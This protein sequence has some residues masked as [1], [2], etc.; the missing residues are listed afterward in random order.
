MRDRLGVE[1]T[2][3]RE[4]RLQHM[5]DRLAAETTE[6]RETSSQRM[7]TNQR[8]RLAVET[9]EERELR[10]ECYSTRYMEQQSVQPQLP[11]F[12]QCFIQAKMRKFHANM[13]TLDVM[14]PFSLMSRPLLEK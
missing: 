13:A 3:E 7:S 9:P 14:P 10:L 8:E 2:E 11:L 12:Q 5:R 6:E 1:T 4:T